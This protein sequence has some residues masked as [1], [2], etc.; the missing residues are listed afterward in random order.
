MHNGAVECSSVVGQGTRF[1]LYFPMTLANR[2]VS[3]EA[4]GY[5]AI[6]S[7]PLRKHG[8]T[9]KVMLVDDEPEICNRLGELLNARG[10]DATAFHDPQEALNYYSQRSES[11]DVVVLDIIMP[12]MDGHTLFTRLREVNSDIRVVIASGYSVESQLEELLMQHCVGYLQKPF[13]CAQLEEILAP[14]ANQTA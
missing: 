10:Y 13:G 3:S 7:T 6:N 2:G 5:R 12:Q 9:L 1:D 14:L 8:R 4:R 11:I